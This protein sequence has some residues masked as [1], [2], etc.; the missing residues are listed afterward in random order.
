MRHR[1]PAGRLA[2]LYGHRWMLLLP[3][4]WPLL[5]VFGIGAMIVDER[6]LTGLPMWGKVV[7]FALSTPIHGDVDLRWLRGRAHAML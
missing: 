7:K 1:A 4:R 2:F 6:A 5:T 3:P